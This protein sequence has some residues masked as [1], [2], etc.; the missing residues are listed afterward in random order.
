MQSPASAGGT[1]MTIV[2]LHIPAS[3]R[4][5]LGAVTMFFGS[6]KLAGVKCIRCRSAY[7]GETHLK[8]EG[9]SLLLGMQGCGECDVKFC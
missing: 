1:S 6:K 3:S 2:I 5:P 9:L 8:A 7:P 4:T